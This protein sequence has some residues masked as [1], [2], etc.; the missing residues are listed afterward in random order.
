MAEKKTQHRTF[1][2]L[3]ETYIKNS[4]ANGIAFGGD[5]KVSLPNKRKPKLVQEHAILVFI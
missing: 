1:A 2:W 3:V 5:I 4:F